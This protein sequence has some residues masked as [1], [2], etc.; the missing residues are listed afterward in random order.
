MFKFKKLNDFHTSAIG[1]FLISFSILVLEITLTK[2]LSVTLWYH[3]S[4]LVI[5]IAMF[6]FGFGGLLVYSLKRH[7]QTFHSENLTLLCLSLAVSI[8]VN[9][10]VTVKYQFPTSI[11]LLSLVR[12]GLAYLLFSAPFV[13][14]SMILS[15]IFLEFKKKSSL[16]YG[17]D[18]LGA[19]LGCIASIYLLTVFPAPKVVLITGLMCVSGA[20]LFDLPKI[21]WLSFSIFVLSLL[22]VFYSD[23]LFKITQT[24]KFSQTDYPPIFEQWSPLA[25]IT[26]TRDIFW[27]GK[28]SDLPFGWEM[29]RNVKNYGRFEQLWIEQDASA[30]TPIVPFDGD[31]SKVEY[32]KYDI[33]AIP[34]YLLNH[35]NVFILG[36]GGGRDV[37][38]ALVFGNKHITGVDIHPIIINL[39]KERFAHY[40]GNIFNHK[41]VK[42]FV[43]EG[44]NFLQSKPLQY[45]LIQIPLIDSWSATVSGAYAMTENSLYTLEAFQIYL[46]HLTPNGMLSITRYYFNPDMQTI[47]IAVLARVALEKLGSDS[48]Q[49]HIVILKNRHIATVLVKRSKFTMAELNKINN[50]SKQLSFPTV[51]SPDGSTNEVLFQQA[52]TTKNLDNFLKQY[53][54]DIRPNTDDRPFFFQMM[55]FSKIKDLFKMNIMDD[56][57][58]NFYG[59]GVLFWLL[60]IST[61]FILI[62]YLLPILFTKEGGKI[63]PFWGLYFILIGLGFMLIEIPI[64]QQGSVYLGSPVYGLSIALF[65]LLCFGGIGSLLSSRFKPSQLKR[66]MLLSFLLIIVT[67]LLFP[68]GFSILKQGS[69]ESSWILKC[70][71]FI[72]LVL[73]MAIALGIP[74]P[75]AFRLIPAGL[76][77]NIPWFWALN[78]AASVLGSII[79]MSLAIAFGYYITSC[80]AA[81]CYSLALLCLFIANLNSTPLVE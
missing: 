39:V 50:L 58:R 61:I 6:G 30:G 67:T 22:L 49:K 33:T 56:Q 8:P 70:L 34:Y 38:T 1:V 4:F 24:K 2:I 9:L 18:L 20:L 74:L 36:V 15:M 65:S 46:R 11:N 12:G 16:V 72:A 42:V 40:A 79:A 5:S 23:S 43:S 14:S 10:Y 25:R 21:K 80:I 19:S 69:Y 41:Y 55:Y 29:S 45:D 26:V 31:Y 3:F 35:A 53:Y 48:P 47:K 81:V 64:V 54:F 17:Y 66:L 62:F 77:S 71:G 28:N 7:F 32:L 75:S 78:G 63:A 52:L 76:S 44:R 37:L 60:I 68:F 59:V 57:F 27:R 51:Y 13:L 73:P